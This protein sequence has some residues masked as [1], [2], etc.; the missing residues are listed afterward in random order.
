MREHRT[1]ESRYYRRKADPGD[2]ARRIARNQR[3]RKEGKGE[4]GRV[5]MMVKGKVMCVGLWKDENANETAQAPQRAQTPFL[6]SPFRSK[7]LT[8]EVDG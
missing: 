3:N 5:V 2:L 7:K 8:L 1:K 4:Q 6:A